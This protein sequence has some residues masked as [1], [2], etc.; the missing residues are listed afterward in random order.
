MNNLFP[1]SYILTVSISMLLFFILHRVIKGA[2]MAQQPQ[3]WR[4]A[5]LVQE[6]QTTTEGVHRQLIKKWKEKNNKTSSPNIN[7]V[8]NTS[9]SSLLCSFYSYSHDLSRREIVGLFMR[10]GWKEN[11]NQHIYIKKIIIKMS[12]MNQI[13]FLF[14]E[15]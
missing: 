8:A 7:V 14:D 6:I 12:P 11:T 1:V 13:C 15:V 9:A 3:A 2:D 4:N 5:S 10:E